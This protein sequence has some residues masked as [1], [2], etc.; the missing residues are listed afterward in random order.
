MHTK[1]SDM[2]EVMRLRE[3]PQRWLEDSTESDTAALELGSAGLG[4]GYV[5]CCSQL[6]CQPFSKT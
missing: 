2:P 4:L 6:D 5:V 1:L 3:L